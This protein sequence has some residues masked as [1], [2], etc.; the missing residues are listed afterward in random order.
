MN[1]IDNLNPAL[2]TQSLAVDNSQKINDASRVQKEEFAKN[3]EAVFIGKLLDEMKNTI[4]SWGFEQDGASQQ[5]QDLFWMNLA[6]DISSQGG[7][8]MWKEIYQS[9]N[10]AENEAGSRQTLDSKL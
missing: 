10:T 3:F 7:L 5:V 4:G 6:Q 2:L 9:L 8:G 1:T